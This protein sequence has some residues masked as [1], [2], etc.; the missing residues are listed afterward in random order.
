MSSETELYRRALAAWGQYEQLLMLAEE[1]SELEAACHQARRDMRN[2][3][4]FVWEEIADVEIMCAQVTQA[5]KAGDAV[6]EIKAGKLRRLEQRLLDTGRGAGR[7]RPGHVGEGNQE[8]QT[9]RE[10]RMTRQ[11]S[12][13]RWL[14]EDTVVKLGWQRG[15]FDE[16]WNIPLRK[17]GR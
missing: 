7:L 16:G 12:S 6:A 11:L 5:L 15:H 2:R 13:A 3:A 14:K 17:L 9:S 10:R 1:C 8:Q 4:H